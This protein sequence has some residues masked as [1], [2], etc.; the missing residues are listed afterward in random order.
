MVNGS[1]FYR[2]LESVSIAS[3]LSTA[4]TI[5]QCQMPA[6]NANSLKLQLLTARKKEWWP[7]TADSLPQAV[8]CQLWNTALVGIEPTTFWLLV[9]CATSCA[10]ETYSA[11]IKY[12]NT[13]SLEIF[14]FHW[15]THTYAV[16][17]TCYLYLQQRFIVSTHSS[18]I[19]FVSLIFIR[20]VLACSSVF[21]FFT[22]LARFSAS[23]CRLLLDQFRLS[24]R[25][26]QGGALRK[27]WEIG[28]WLLWGAL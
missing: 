24:V 20:I 28:L 16:V 17:E 26:W 14:L 18:V 23:W 19:F 11:Y 3:A 8:T 13:A 4:F 1:R 15:T 12:T 22:Y 5:Y 7:A 9:R 6:I 10:T 25:L 2:A 21:V 27:R